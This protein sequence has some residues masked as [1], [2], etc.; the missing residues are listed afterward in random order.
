MFQVWQTCVEPG[1]P[2]E[3]CI[4]VFIFEELTNNSLIWKDNI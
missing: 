3:K 2:T 4:I 1:E